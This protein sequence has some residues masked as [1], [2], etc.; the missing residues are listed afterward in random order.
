ML[1]DGQ[2][3]PFARHRAD[4]RALD[5]LRPLPQSLNLL[6]D[7]RSEL[8]GYALVDVATLDGGA[9]LARVC[10][11]APDGCLDR[12]AEVC[13]LEDYHRVFAAQLKHDRDESSRGCFGHASARG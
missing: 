1:F 6:D 7:A 12:G 8:F 11:R 4:V 9:G 10:E 13:V 5:A 3:L 2:Q